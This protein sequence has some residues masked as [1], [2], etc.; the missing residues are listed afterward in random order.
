MTVN[1]HAPGKT[2]KYNFI[3]KTITFFHVFCLSFSTG[4]ICLYFCP[5]L[6]IF[7]THCRLTCCRITSLR[8]WCLWTRG[9]VAAR[10][11]NSSPGS[12]RFST[13]TRCLISSTAALCPGAYVG[14]TRSELLCGRFNWDNFDST[15]IQL[16]FGWSGSIYF[17]IYYI[18][19]QEKCDGQNRNLVGTIEM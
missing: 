2:K 8:C 13:P 14:V 6:Q 5:V 7:L 17:A 3:I 16:R 11:S 9:V 19:S 1:V 15:R 4:T 12:R 18:I 10:V